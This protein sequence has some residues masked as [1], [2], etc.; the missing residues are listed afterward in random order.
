M[1]AA[2]V[3]GGSGFI[4]GKLIRALVANGVMVRALGRSGKALQK[5]GDL[6]ATAIEGDLDDRDALRTGMANCDVVFHCASY[7]NDWDREAAR[8]V[9]IVGTQNV[10]EA[11][12]AAGVKRI[13][14]A[15][16]IGVI[17]GD[18]PAINV[19][20]TRPRG[21]PVGVLCATRVQSEAIVEAAS[22][23][24]LETV[25]TRFPYV[26]GQGDT[27]R[28]ILLRLIRSRRFRWVGGGHH[29]I[30]ICHVDDAVR[31]MILA[32]SRGRP[33][34][35]Y[36]I[37]DDVRIE[38]RA[39]VQAQLAVDGLS[40]PDRSVPPWLARLLADTMSFTLE[41]VGSKRPSPLTPTSVRF[42][43]QQTTVDTTRARTELGFRPASRWP[44]ALFTLRPLD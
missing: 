17:V 31:G 32:A 21:R 16:G 9:N 35:I 29:L 26:W 11:A 28:P 34:A 2:F 43:G 1:D 5:V 30:S 10:L 25:I 8:R 39:F 7:L 22:S 19:D 15:S 23:A 27:L 6:G 36:W 12:R 37:A 4:G 13:V 18:G 14:Y 40:A 41:L 20:E 33:G 44:D 38:L 3:T 42:L 24:S